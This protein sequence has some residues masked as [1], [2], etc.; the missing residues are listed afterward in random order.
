MMVYVHFAEQGRYTTIQVAT[1][2]S[3][4]LSKANQLF[5][6]CVAQDDFQKGVVFTL[7][8]G[9]GGYSLNR[10]GVAGTPL[11][12]ENYNPE[13]LSGYDH[14]VA[15]LNTESPCGRLVILSGEPGSGKTYLV[16]ALLS[17]V[18]KAAYVLVPSHLVGDLSG[19]EIL[20]AL[21]AAKSEFNGPIVLIIEDADRVLVNRKEGD[22][23]AISAMLNLGDGILGAV[24]D[25]RILATT[26]AETLEMDPATQRPGRLCQHIR[27]GA[28]S[29]LEANK[30]F[31]R[32][33]GKQVNFRQPTT[34]AEVYKLA[35]KF[36]WAPPPKESSY[37]N[38][39]KELL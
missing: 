8:R 18:P 11:E 27:V 34:L 13:V 29:P 15:D 3:G 33:T 10:L 16:R 32:L 36:G 19:P 39:R 5:S 17:Q 31:Q 30:A 2:D 9:M 1:N 22:M 14:V 4:L 20:P 35:R 7:A 12:R 38:L 25:V 24:L 6:R 28:L 21:T 23:D 37:P 26:N